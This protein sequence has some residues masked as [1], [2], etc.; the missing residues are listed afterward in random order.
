[1]KRTAKTNTKQL[2]TV[3]NIR[4]FVHFNFQ[5]NILKISLFPIKLVVSCPKN[6]SL[7]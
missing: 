6:Y 2:K 3:K 1:M 4:C 5:I 7:L